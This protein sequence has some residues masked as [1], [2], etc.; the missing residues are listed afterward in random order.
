MTP[1]DPSALCGA[2][3]RPSREIATVL[4]ELAKDADQCLRRILADL[5]L[6]L[7]KPIATVPGRKRIAPRG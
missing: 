7:T 5:S 6:R 4:N 2:E 1:I 3:R